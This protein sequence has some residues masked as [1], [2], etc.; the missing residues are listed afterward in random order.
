MLTPIPFVFETA[1]PLCESLLKKRPLVHCLTNNVVQHFTANM[2][3]AAGA[4]PAMIIAREEVA[5]FVPHAQSCLINIGTVTA[6]MAASMLLAAQTC[7]RSEIPWVLDPVAVGNALPYRTNLAKQLL[8]YDPTVIRGNA[9]EILVLAGKESQAK[10]P[11]SQIESETIYTEAIALAQKQHTIVAV[12]GKKD[13]ITDGQYCYFVAGG[14]VLLT[15]ITGTGC[16]LSA[17][18][19][20]FNGLN[21]DPLLATASASAMMKEAAN[22]S[23]IGCGPATFALSL[24]DSVSML[25]KTGQI[26]S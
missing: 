9:A 13:Y 21:E 1:L 15:Q 23:K 11:D 4:I 14:D 10:G 16:A 18:I 6:S 8:R 25:T 5:D 17:L 20:A 3:L 22:R 19:A 24:L 12:T 26:K 7:Q 2:L